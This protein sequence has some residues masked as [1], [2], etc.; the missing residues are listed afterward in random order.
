MP[1][2]TLK[3]IPEE[4]MVRLR[5]VAKR[6]R[7]SVMQEALYLLEG[8]VAAREN[9]LGSPAG[10]VQSQV[11]RW[12]ALAGKWQSSESFDAEIAGIMAARTDGRAVDL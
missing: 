1:A 9:A 7:R 2:L 12:R 11:G 8:G 4:L 10:A 5:A 6:E 3:E